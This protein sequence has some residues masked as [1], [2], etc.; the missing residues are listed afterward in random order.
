MI[1]II[2]NLSICK[3]VFI[4]GPVWYM[5]FPIPMYTFIEKNNLSRK[6]IIPVT[7]YEEP[8]LSN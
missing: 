7:A 1:K 8:R 6:I 5:S 2:P 3:K 4:E